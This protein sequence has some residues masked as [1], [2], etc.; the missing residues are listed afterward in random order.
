[1]Q[2][3]LL[4]V[5]V[6]QQSGTIRGVW[7]VILK[8]ERLIYKKGDVGNHIYM[9]TAN[10][11]IKNNGCLT[12]GAGCAKAV[13]D[14]YKGI[15]KMFGYIIEDK[16]TFKCSWVC[17]TKE[18]YKQYIGDF[19]TKILWQEESP[20]P[21]VKDSITCLTRVAGLRPSYTFHMPCPAVSNGGLSE[22]EVL[23]LLTTL[24]DNVIIYIN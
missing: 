3:L 14:I 11:T 20:L 5:I 7:K 6:V 13:R 8:R 17:Y 10:S 2:N 15:D 23:P 18:P 1:M 22:K 19:Q 16:S 9:F 21:L 4:H 24:P 12:M